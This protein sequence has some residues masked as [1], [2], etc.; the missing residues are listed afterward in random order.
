MGVKIR[1]ARTGA[2]KKPYY[3]IVVCNSSA[4]RDGKFLEQVGSYNPM[5]DSLDKNRVV[6][7][8]NR[9]KYWTSVGAQP[10]ERIKKIF[11]KATYVER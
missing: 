8:K 1:L 10:T 7:L 4:P 9:I 6:L 3:K 11:K 2:R 5:L